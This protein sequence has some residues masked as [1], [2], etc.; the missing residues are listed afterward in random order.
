MVSV[1]ERTNLVRNYAHKL[2]FENVGFAKAQHLSTEATFLEKWLSSG[3][4]GTMSWMENHFD[5]RVDPRKLV[6][7]AKTVICVSL[8][9]YEKDIIQTENTPQ[10]SKYALGDDYHDVVRER[11]R[12][13]FNYIKELCGNVDGRVF[14]DSAPVMDKAWAARSGL[15]WLGKNGNILNK[16]LGSWFFLGEIILD[17]EFEYDKPTTDHCGSCT[18]CIEACP[19]QA[20]IEPMVV[21]ARK[22]IS[23]LTIEYKDA[24]SDDQS[25]QMGNW[26]YGCDICQD[27]CPWNSKAPSTREDRFKPRKEILEMTMETWKK[28]DL[29]TY[30]KLFKNSAVKRTKYPGLVRNISIAIQNIDQQ[31]G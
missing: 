3:M 19:T 20:I 11:L 6:P 16:S 18:K 29:E 21:D 15:G 31:L 27:V 1:S 24:I 10:I 23:Y 5:L 7:N 13:L 9:Y 12:V 30:R 14:T 22:C 17:L 28:I 25:K 2:G 4:H 8:Q 26:M